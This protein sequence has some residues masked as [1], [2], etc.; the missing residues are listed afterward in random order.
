MK[1]YLKL[2]RFLR[3]HGKLFAAASVLMLLSSLFEGVQFSMMVPLVDRIF[4]KK[5]ITL[6]NPELAPDFIVDFIQKLNSTPPDKLLT[7]LV[8]AFFLLLLTKHIVTFWYSFL[9]NDISQRIMRDIRFRLY[10]TIQH[11]SL[12]YFSRKRGGEL[13]SRITNDVQVVENAVSYGVTDLFRQSFTILMF[14]TIAFT[15]HYKA[16]LVLLVLFPLIGWP[17][18]QIGRKLKK[19]SRSSQEKM[20]DI[21]SLLLETISGIKVVKAFCME[22]HEIRRFWSQNRDF[23]KLK[24]KSIR[25]MLFISPITEIMGGLFGALII[26]WLGRQVMEDV[27]SFGV[28]VLF[29]GSIMSI[30]SPIKKLGNVN[31]LT[32]Q[33]LAANTR[34]YEIL[35]SVPTVVEKPGAKELPPI[36]NGITFENVSFH[37]EQESGDILRDI[38][39]EIKVGEMVAI[40]GPTGMGKSTLANLIPRFY[41]PTQG[42]VRIDGRDLREVTLKSLRSQIG[43]VTQ[44]TILFNDTVR[45]N[46]AYGHPEATREEV[47]AAALKAFA[48]RFIVKMPQGYDTVLGDRGFRLSGGEKQRIAIARAIL[49]NPPILLLDEATSQLDSESE[50]IVQEA[51]DRLMQERTVIAIAHRL[52]TIKKATKI[53]VL[54]HGRIVGLDRHEKLLETCPLYKRLHETQFQL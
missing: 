5:P 20:A 31:A 28:F 15:I 13:I 23:Y 1:D 19:L 6:P 4:T 29:F 21:N 11:L 39:L 36:K 49:K 8:V 17:I 7:I 54:E 24:M 16:T 12:D 51:L 52:S 45:N 35:E 41:D 2:L 25:R 34:I 30:I 53:V 43:N 50:K 14:M 33:A 9:M 3:G 32:Q 38:N 47:E 37:Y 18:S 42:T 46:I 10:E 27:L 40:V 48:H 26:F 44:E 22:D